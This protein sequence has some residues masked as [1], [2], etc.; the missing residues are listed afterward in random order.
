MSQNSVTCFFEDSKGL[1]WVGTQDGLNS[2][3]GKTFTHFEHD[4]M[5]TNSLSNKYILKIS[6][7]AQGYIWVGTAFG[8]NRLNPST[9]KI[10][11]VFID[12]ENERKFSSSIYE[13]FV[14]DDENTLLLLN[15]TILYS[16]NTRTLQTKKESDIVSKHL[17]ESINKKDQY[18]IRNDSIHNLK[19]PD[20]QYEIKQY[21]KSHSISKVAANQDFILFYS[22]N[23]K[24]ELDVFDLKLKRFIDPI[25]VPSSV[26]SF[27]IQ[28][29]NSIHIAMK[30]GFMLF[31]QKEFNTVISFDAANPQSIPSGPILSTFTDSKKNV[32]IG[33]STSGIAVQPSSFSNFTLI[34]SIHKND[35]IQDISLHENEIIIASNT[36]I[37]RVQKGVLSSIKT[38]GADRVNAVLK[39][40]GFIYAAVEQ[41]GLFK[42][43]ANGNILQHYTMSN[44]ALQTNQV[45]A[46]RDLGNEIG[47]CTEKQFYIINNQNKIEWCKVNE[48]PNSYS[49]IVNCSVDQNGQLFLATNNGI[50]ILNNQRKITKLISSISNTDVLGKTII[51]NVVSYHD[52]LLISTLSNGIFLMKNNEVIQHY[53]RN[54]GLQNN[55]VYNAIRL[56]NGNIWACTNAGISRLSA[57]ARNF[58]S[59]NVYNGLPISYYSFGSMQSSNDSVVVGTDNGLY[60]VNDTQLK[61]SDIKFQPYIHQLSVNGKNEGQLKNEIELDAYKKNVEINF[62]Y[63]TLFDNIVI[64]YQLNNLPWVVLPIN[65]N[66][67]NFSNFPLGH[68]SLSIK[69]ATNL[70]GLDSASMKTY[71]IYV[72]TP[73]YLKWWVLTISFIAMIAFIFYIIKNY[74]KRKNEQKIMAFQNELN[75]QKERERI[76]RDLHDNL[77]SYATALL[78]KIQ[79]MK[80]KDSHNDINEMNELG[81]RIIS[82]IRE[83]IW[84]MQTKDI[85][86][87]DFSDKIKN[88]ILKLNPAYPDLKMNVIDVIDQNISLTP[89]IT[90]HLFRI[91]QE[92]IH[93]C[94]KHAKAN[95]LTITIRANNE[96]DI[97]IED[98]G[99]GYIPKHEVEHYGIQNMKERAIEIGYLFEIRKTE[100]GTLIHLSSKPFLEQSQP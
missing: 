100:S 50:V 77:G 96:I 21:A 61:L 64:A 68:N 9:G 33:T 67:I 7:D 26:S 83:T 74:F 78:S 57:G 63:A 46:I 11:R 58:E 39:K 12:F 81:N 76:S 25:K 27:S 29:D 97:L 23:M 60:I 18:I 87:Q 85:K 6:E 72:K 59:I 89:T 95:Q 37:Y 5:D 30:N 88:Y 73:W 51:S 8:L 98:N 47:V 94:V 28:E 90:T 19:R 99:I 38:F 65:Q 82:N 2:F 52:T 43:S 4:P 34:P 53:H 86:L 70:A 93:N 44:S 22:E 55:V 1:I 13:Q 91:V 48:R 84:I 31:K 17:V 49:Y 71:S 24:D 40:N 16:I 54:S 75:I 66:R 56:R 79:Q 14:F 62:G 45:L 42:L 36:G 80:T 35:A 69:S 3:D 20:Q 10:N 41:K 32:W 15:K 92:A